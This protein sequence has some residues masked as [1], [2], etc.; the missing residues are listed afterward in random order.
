MILLHILFI[1]ILYSNSIK[2]VVEE[3][4]D[5]KTPNAEVVFI[6]KHE[7]STKPSILAYVI[8]LKMRQIG[9]TIN[10]I[11]KLK[12]FKTNK[13]HLNDLVDEN[14][15][16]L[17]VRYIRLLL[18]ENTPS[19][20]GYKNFIDEDKLFLKQEMTKEEDSDCLYYYIIKNTSL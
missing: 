11:S 5:L 9:E 15:Y 7:S 12:I 8:A 1:Q 14:P 6:K 16:N 18:Q 17:H 10:P 19:F 2:D 13:M 20:L 3:F 4:H